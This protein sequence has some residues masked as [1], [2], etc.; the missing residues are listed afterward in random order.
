MAEVEFDLIVEACRRVVQEREYAGIG[1]RPHPRAILMAVVYKAHREGM[2]LREAERWCLENLDKLKKVGWN[3]PNPPKKS[4]L[5]MIMK[6][7]DAA[8]LQRITAKIKHLK[9]EVK[10]LWF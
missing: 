5:H 8:T 6:E 4:T 9:G 2:S 1:R 7:I 10:T 3:K